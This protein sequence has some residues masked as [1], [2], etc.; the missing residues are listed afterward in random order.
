VSED[1]HQCRENTW[2]EPPDKAMDKWVMTREEEK[3]TKAPE[4]AILETRSDN[5]FG[6]LEAEL[7]QK[8]EINMR[9]VNSDG[10]RD[11]H[12]SLLIWKLYQRNKA[13]ARKA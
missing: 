12:R 10:D 5:L 7:T 6:Q 3:L 2:D 11:L 1:T 13:V 9:E 8:S 4:A